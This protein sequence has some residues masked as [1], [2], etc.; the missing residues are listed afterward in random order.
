MS[1]PHE[2]RYQCHDESDNNQENNTTRRLRR[3]EGLDRPRDDDRRGRWL[4]DGRLPAD[5]TELGFFPQ[6]PPTADTG[7]NIH[8]TPVTPTRSSHSTHRR[9]N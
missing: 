7:L 3:P 4:L 1:H 5:M 6:E 8:A 9:G 2:K